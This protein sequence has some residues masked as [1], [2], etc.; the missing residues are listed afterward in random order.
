M[1]VCFPVKT[2]G[3]T[4]IIIMFVCIRIRELNV[5]WTEPGFLSRIFLFSCDFWRCLRAGWAALTKANPSSLYRYFCRPFHSPLP[6]GALKCLL[7]LCV[8]VFRG[9]FYARWPTFTFQRHAVVSC[10]YCMCS[11]RTTVN[12]PLTQTSSYTFWPFLWYG[13]PF[14]FHLKGK[15]AE[16]IDCERSRNEREK[17]GS[18]HACRVR[19]PVHFSFFYLKTAW[20]ATPFCLPTHVY[21]TL[22]S[23]VL[24]FSMHR[25]EHSYFNTPLLY[26]VAVFCR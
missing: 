5:W 14:T 15:V 19:F 12:T 3:M 17:F 4:I 11:V 16:K 24:L 9:G 2:D 25:T 7:W 13:I 23:L 21:N 8:V 6:R 22:Y 20:P 10:A 18:L 1:C 26:F